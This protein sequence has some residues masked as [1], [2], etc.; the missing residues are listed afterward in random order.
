M[1]ALHACLEM[2]VIFHGAEKRIG[3]FW[4]D[5]SFPNVKRTLPEHCLARF[6]RRSRD[7]NPGGTHAPYSL[8]RGAPSATWVLLHGGRFDLP[9]FIQEG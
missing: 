9:F 3:C 6:W 7:L 8:S 2:A 1:F 5:F 4:R